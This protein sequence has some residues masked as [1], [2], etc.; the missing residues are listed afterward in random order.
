MIVPILSHFYVITT[1]CSPLNLEGAVIYMMG[2]SEDIQD[3]QF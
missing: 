1:Y 3:Q 2:Q